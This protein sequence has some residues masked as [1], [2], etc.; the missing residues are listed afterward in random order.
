MGYVLEGVLRK[1]KKCL[2]TGIIHDQ[3][4]YGLLKEDWKKARKKLV[5]K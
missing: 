2:A 1:R 4:M 3:N 5:N